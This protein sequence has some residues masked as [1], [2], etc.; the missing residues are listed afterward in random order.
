MIFSSLQALKP[1]K[2]W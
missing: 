1:E 2:P